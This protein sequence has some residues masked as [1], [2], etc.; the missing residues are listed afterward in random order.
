[1]LRQS[2]NNPMFF[3]ARRLPKRVMGS[4]GTR[5]MCW[6]PAMRGAG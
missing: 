2:R 3:T 5:A 1:L 4:G 6:G